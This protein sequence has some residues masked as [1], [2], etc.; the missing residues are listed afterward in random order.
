ML[1]Y[2]SFYWLFCY[3][4]K[5]SYTLFSLF[6]SLRISICLTTH[7]PSIC[8][9]DSD[10]M[11]PCQCVCS[12]GKWTRCQVLFGCD[13]CRWMPNRLGTG[14]SLNTS[15]HI[16]SIALTTHSLMGRFVVRHW[17]SYITLRQPFFLSTLANFFFLIF[18]LKNCLTWV[19]RM[20]VSK[21]ASTDRWS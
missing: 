16:N 18:W 10:E 19:Q 5:G 4:V 15:A 8:W 12:T 14:H 17:L 9:S 6:S 13:G 3:T 2:Y 1:F 21:F 7:T 20:N 11:C